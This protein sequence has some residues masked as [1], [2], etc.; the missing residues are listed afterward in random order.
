MILESPSSLRVKSFFLT[1]KCSLYF[2][3]PHSFPHCSIIL[4]IYKLLQGTTVSGCGGE[5]QS[6]IRT[7]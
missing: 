2:G 7:F 1:P 6:R 5:V 3:P 4:D